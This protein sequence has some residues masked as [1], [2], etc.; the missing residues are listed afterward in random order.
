MYLVQVYCCLALLDT[1]R[2][3]NTVCFWR[4]WD[5]LYIRCLAA[6]ISLLQLAIVNAV[7]STTKQQMLFRI[8]EGIAMEYGYIK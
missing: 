6:V 7:P 3:G 5:N 4:S 8:R 1:Y 2:N